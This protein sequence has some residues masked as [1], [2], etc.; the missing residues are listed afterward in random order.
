MMESDDSNVEERNN[1]KER[2]NHAYFK[3]L[4]GPFFMFQK[5]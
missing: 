2:E 1:V 5:E 3:D 4:Q